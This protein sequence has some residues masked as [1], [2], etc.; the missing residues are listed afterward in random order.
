MEFLSIIDLKQFDEKA[1][2]EY[3]IVKKD[4]KDRKCL[5][6]PY[7]SSLGVSYH[8]PYTDGVGHSPQ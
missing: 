4:L 7:S 5:I 2:K 6:G 8:I 1:A 3:G